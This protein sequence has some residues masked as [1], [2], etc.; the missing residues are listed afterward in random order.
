MGLDNDYKDDEGD[1]SKVNIEWKY[2]C[3]V[4]MG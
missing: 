3:E 4:D 1:V 2:K